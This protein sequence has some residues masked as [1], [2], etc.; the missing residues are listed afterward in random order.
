MLV[1]GQNLPVGIYDV[2]RRGSSSAEGTSNQV[3]KGARSQSPLESSYMANNAALKKKKAA[4]KAS[5]SSYSGHT[6]GNPAR[7]NT[8][9][10]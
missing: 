10:N 4:Y 2:D 6:N 5:E 7:K 3:R 1:Q 8:H 9:H